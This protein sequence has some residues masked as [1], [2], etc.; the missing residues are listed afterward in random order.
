MQIYI[1]DWT[2]VLNYYI[3]YPRDFYV[4]F[5]FRKNGVKLEE[6]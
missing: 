1:G 4:S 2:N 5:L 6:M 3:P